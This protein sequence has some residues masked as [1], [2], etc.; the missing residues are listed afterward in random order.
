MCCR[1][2]VASDMS[3]SFEMV[4]AQEHE[5]TN[6]E[7]LFSNTTAAPSSGGGV[8]FVS[9]S[10]LMAPSVNTAQDHAPF[11]SMSLQSMTAQMLMLLTR[12]SSQ[13]PPNVEELHAHKARSDDAAVELQQRLTMAQAQLKGQQAT[14]SDLHRRLD[15][16]LRQSAQLQ[17]S[18]RVLQ[19]SFRS[20]VERIERE[21][22][23]LVRRIGEHQRQEQ[24]SD[25][26]GFTVC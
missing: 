8:G 4:P 14:I 7:I 18:Q 12:M 17:S 25:A 10:A 24:V 9:A 5:A 21:K 19:S 6:E 3:A 2:L 26:K 22:A 13:V 1:A 20:D 11:S 15:A 23:D 16:A